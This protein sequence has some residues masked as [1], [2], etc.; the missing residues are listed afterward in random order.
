MNLNWSLE[1]NPI[2]SKPDILS[3]AVPI[4]SLRKS[5]L[6]HADLRTGSRKNFAYQHLEERIKIY[7]DE[8]FP[9]VVH[10]LDL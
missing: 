6:K 10:K 5:L 3:W 4:T 7:D 1:T 9:Y 2:L 8:S